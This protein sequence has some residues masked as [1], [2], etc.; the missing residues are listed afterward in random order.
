MKNRKII[1]IV[2]MFIAILGLTFV[3][4]KKDSPAT[5]A[6]T[7]SFTATVNGIQVSINTTATNATSYAWNFG[8]TINVS[9]IQSTAQNMVHTYKVAGTYN[10]TVTVTGPGGSVTEAQS[11]A[12]GAAPSGINLKDNSFADWDTVAVAWM[13]TDT[14][15]LPKA[16]TL[17]FLKTRQTSDSLYV[18]LETTSKLADSTIICMFFDADNSPATVYQTW[19]Y[20]KTASAFD[21]VYQ[22]TLFLGKEQNV[23]KFSE[24]TASGNWSWS[25]LADKNFTVIG[26][27]GASK[28]N[29]ANTA[30]EFAYLKAKMAGS[31]D[32]KITMGIYEADKSWSEI[33]ILPSYR[34]AAT[35]KPL[36]IKLVN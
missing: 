1:G 6:P 34:H 30:I 8:D 14:L 23:Q 3:G 10:I 16:S 36:V 33:G 32:T 17:Q 13:S 28:T 9:A 21:Y 27:I 15:G 5:P 22:G 26:H 12:T 35:N 29:P 2:L 20:D 19:M 31:W 24:A 18:Y 4:C 11:I 7:V 25:P